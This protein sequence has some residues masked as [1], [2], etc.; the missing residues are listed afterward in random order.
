MACKKMGSPHLKGCTLYTSAEPC[1]MCL[2]ATYWARI[3]KIYVGARY[4]GVLL[5][6]AGRTRG[7]FLLGRVS[8]SPSISPCVSCFTQRTERA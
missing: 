1:P 4:E 5:V 8:H 6:E 2:A 7:G 3:D